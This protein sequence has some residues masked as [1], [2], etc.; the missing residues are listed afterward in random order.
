MKEFGILF[1]GIIIIIV[2]VMHTPKVLPKPKSNNYL[3]GVRHEIVRCPGDGNCLF[4]A[5]SFSVDEPCEK[6]RRRI[7]KELHQHREKYMGFF[8]P[9]GLHQ[10][11]NG[12]DIMDLNHTTYDKYLVNML[13]PGV[14]GGEMEIAAA[15]EVYRR[16]VIVYS[17]SIYNENSRYGGNAEGGNAEG[18]GAH[19]IKIYYNGSSHYDAIRTS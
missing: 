9:S 16:P 18:G 5:I 2:S 17:K 8:T 3:P 12:R 19:P 4:H 14:W 15:A 1:S 13:N 10:P 11:R 6:V 7:V